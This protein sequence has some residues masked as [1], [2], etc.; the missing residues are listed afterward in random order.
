MI[1]L[2]R[3]R[4]GLFALS[5]AVLG[6]VCAL[7]LFALISSPADAAKEPRP[8]QLVEVEAPALDGFASLERRS[9]NVSTALQDELGNRSGLFD[10]DPRTLVAVDTAEFDRPV[11]IAPTSDGACLFIPAPEGGFG[12]ACSDHQTVEEGHLSVT[13]GKLTA[14]LVPDD[15]STVIAKS[16][17]SSDRAI[18]R[19]NIA[20]NSIDNP[21]TLLLDG[22]RY[23]LKGR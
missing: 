3:S 8:Y 17:S 10:G 11:V 5:A 20:I 7:V 6:A 12:G 14:T 16:G 22:D 1:H 13:V 2:I 9:G 23:A 4:T 21:D 18:V 19:D 15:I